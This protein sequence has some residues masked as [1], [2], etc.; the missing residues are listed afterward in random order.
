MHY[1]THAVMSVVFP[2]SHAQAS[3]EEVETAAPVA[4]Q[5]QQVVVTNVEAVEPELEV[6][7]GGEDNVHVLRIVVGV[8]VAC[9]KKS[10][11]GCPKQKP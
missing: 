1:A 5:A 6:E 11:A 3:T 10:S 4:Q 8:Q 2:A 9:R 7:D